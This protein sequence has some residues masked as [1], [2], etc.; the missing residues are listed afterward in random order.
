[1]SDDTPALQSL[2]E[3]VRSAAAELGEITHVPRMA[4]VDPAVFEA[5]ARG[6]IPFVI[7]G[8]VEHWPVFRLDAAA[9]KERFGFLQVQ[10]R[11]GDY[12]A[13]AFTSQRQV[14]SMSLSQYLDGLESP[15]GELPP[16]V[17]NQN[18]DGIGSLCRWPPYFKQLDAA[19][20][21]LGPA[22]TITPLHCD[23]LENLFAQIWG[24]KRFTLYPPHCAQVL[25]AKQANPRLYKS[26]FDPDAPDFQQFPAAR[27]LRAVECIVNPGEL[28][29]LPAGWFHHVQSLDLSLSANCWS[30]D[31]PLALRRRPVSSKQPPI[32]S[33]AAHP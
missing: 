32:S 30:R 3:A 25:Q 2:R 21:W 18:I 15:S 9:L 8:L 6:G 1:M 10:V 16:Y 26:T 31:R 24:R 28:L 5:L 23:Y 29:Y 17:G 27:G 14:A 7:V 12:V 4:P 20:T 19:R 11:H 33:L 22:G 13:K